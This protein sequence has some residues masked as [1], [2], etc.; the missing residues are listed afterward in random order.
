[1]TKTAKTSQKTTTHNSAKKKAITK[2]GSGSK[3]KA[4]PKIT[5]VIE[6]YKNQKDFFK[7]DRGLLDK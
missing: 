7:M 6:V 4:S 1:M 5:K 2:S 3:A